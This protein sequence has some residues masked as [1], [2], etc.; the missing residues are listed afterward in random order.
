MQL[1]YIHG[2]HSLCVRHHNAFRFRWK[3]FYTFVNKGNDTLYSTL[4][5]FSSTWV[6][7]ES[8]YGFLPNSL[9]FISGNKWANKASLCCCWLC[10]PLL[11]LHHLLPP[12]N[13]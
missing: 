4:E 6:Y 3:L 5:N 7:G 12:S 1:I 2:F 10:L 11:L 8:L 13:P 9:V